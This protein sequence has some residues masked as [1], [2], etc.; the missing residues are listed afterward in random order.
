MTKK[1]DNNNVRIGDF[2]L[3]NDIITQAQLDEALL[4]QKDNPERLIGE[5][6]V[7]LGFLTKE[8]LVM[9]L[10]MFFM[11]TEAQP[12]FID[13]WLDQD[14]IDMIQEKISKKESEKKE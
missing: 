1:D 3:L 14:E 4:M 11:T 9:S 10:E 5:I 7:T 2:L 13:E 12:V 6:L 8:E